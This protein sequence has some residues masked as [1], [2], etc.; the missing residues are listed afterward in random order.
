M[1][2]V[3]LAE[4]LNLGVEGALNLCIFSDI[5]W[6]TKNIFRKLVMCCL[7]ETPDQPAKTY[8]RGETVRNAAGHPPGFG[9]ETEHFNWSISKQHVV[10]NKQVFFAGIV[11]K[12]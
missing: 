3:Q 5:L 2:Y 4:R 6:R 8:H 9:E 7:D 10:A 1:K 11:Y 12:W